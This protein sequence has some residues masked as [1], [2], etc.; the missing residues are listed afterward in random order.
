VARPLSAD[1]SVVITTFQRPERLAGCLDGVRAQTRP[2]D[3]VV[4]VVHSTDRASAGHV[5]QSAAEWPALRWVSVDKAGSLA[6]LNCGLAAARKSIVA[7]IDDDAVPA[8]DWLERIVQTFERDESI[9]AVGGRDYIVGDGQPDNGDAKRSV[10]RI[11]WFGRMIGNHHIGVG[12]PRDVE[13]LKGTNMSFRHSAVAAHAFDERLRGYG[14]QVHSELSICLPLRRQRLRVVYDPDIAV[15]HY[16]APRPHGDDRRHRTRGVVF[17]FSHNEALEIL[18]YFG[19]LQRIVYGL[20]AFGI[21]T[22]YCPGVLVLT[23]DLISREPAAWDRFRAAQRGRASAWRTRRTAPRRAL[24]GPLL[25]RPAPGWR[26]RH[27]FGALGIRP[28]IAQHSHAE[29]ALLMRHAAGAETIV[30]LGVAEG[31]SAAELRAAMSP[32]GHLYLVD[33]YEPG[34]LGVSFGWVVA[35]RAVNGVHRGHVTWL[36]SRSD[37][38]VRSWRRPI[39]FLFIDADHSYERAAGDWRL[40]TP[41]VR[42]GGRVAL[43]DSAVFPGGWTDER[44][45][46]VHLLREILS[47]GL[48]WSLVDQADSL[49]I[50]RRD[51]A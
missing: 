30:E 33:P 7:F 9:A 44:S 1:V 24:R 40:W 23:R 20:W 46:P 31:G 39:D 38:A 12:P 13:V 35:H 48:G 8:T 47:T 43:H 14:S 36:R 19:P 45:G 18:D 16:P 49:S 29:A 4:V 50:L 3:E 2:A 51:E 42:P 27:V 28:P 10:G 17:T 34:R 26:T 21:G 37:A 15:T 32:T 6:A 5:E 25:H 11:Q 22:T 41:F